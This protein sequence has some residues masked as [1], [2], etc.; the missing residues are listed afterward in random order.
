MN[1]LRTV[2]EIQPQMPHFYRPPCV[3]EKSVAIRWATSSGSGSTLVYVIA[4][5][6]QDAFAGA[7]A[8][9]AERFA[10]FGYELLGVSAA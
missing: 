10:P 6:M 4:T 1:P 3:N 2:T 5:N 7:R 9:F 8:H